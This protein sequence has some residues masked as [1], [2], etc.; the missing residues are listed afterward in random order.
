MLMNK[1]E[2]CQK[3]VVLL[4]RPWTYQ[5]MLINITVNCFGYDEIIIIIIIIIISSSSSSSTSSSSS[6]ICNRKCLWKEKTYLYD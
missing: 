5:L 6:S 4:V 1:V 3:V 2:F